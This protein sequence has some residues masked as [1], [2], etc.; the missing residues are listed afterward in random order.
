MKTRCYQ[1]GVTLIEL[2]IA[3]AIMGILASIA[4]PSY[5]SYVSKSNRTEAMRELVRIA[6]LQE[7]FFMDNRT[8]TADMTQLNLGADPYI[9]ADGQHYSIDATIANSGTTYV[10]TATARGKQASNDTSCTTLT[11]NQLGKKD[12][13][14]SDCWEK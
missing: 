13:E 2:M 1:L 4:Y 7:Q 12:A 9:S 5:T 6:N 11:I 10:L 8:Y 3:V 14:S